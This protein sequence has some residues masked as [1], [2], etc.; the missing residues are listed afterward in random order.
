MAIFWVF[1]SL[2][3]YLSYQDASTPAIGTIS[4]GLTEPKA[5]T[6]IPR[7]ADGSVVLTIERGQPGPYDDLTDSEYDSEDEAK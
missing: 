1:F 7:N 2:F 6:D 3:S 5:Q 4:S